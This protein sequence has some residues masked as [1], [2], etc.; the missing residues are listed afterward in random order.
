MLMLMV[1]CGDDEQMQVLQRI[2]VDAVVINRCVYN[3]RTN[4]I[5]HTLELLCRVLRGRDMII[6]TRS[7]ENTMAQQTVKFRH[8]RVHTSAGVTQSRRWPELLASFAF[9]SLPDGGCRFHYTCRLR[10]FVAASANYWMMELPAVLWRFEAVT[11]APTFFLIAE[12]AEP[13]TAKSSDN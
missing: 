12:E 8:Q 9:T 1:D 3:P 5:G 6:T 2:N 11:V 13:P 10:N 7:L 4:A